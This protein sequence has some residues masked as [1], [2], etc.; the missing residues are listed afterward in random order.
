MNPKTLVMKV[1][2][3]FKLTIIAASLLF[4]QGTVIAQPGLISLSADESA[5]T[6]DVITRLYQTGGIDLPPGSA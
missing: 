4:V 5:R 1:K 2:L 3:I 6:Y